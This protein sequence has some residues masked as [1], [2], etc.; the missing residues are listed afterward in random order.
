MSEEF[1]AE[2]D[3]TPGEIEEALRQLLAARHAEAGL[4]APARVLNLVAVVDGRYRGEVE[5]RL[6][7][8]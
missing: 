1:W 3:T 6:E 5:N 2:Q 7:R 8:A 4:V